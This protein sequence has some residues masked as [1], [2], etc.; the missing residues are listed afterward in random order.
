[1]GK[2]RGWWFAWTPLRD[3]YLPLADAAVGSSHEQ[4]LESDRVGSRRTRR[5]ARAHGRGVR[6]R[7]SADR[8]ASR[9]TDL[10][11]DDTVLQPQPHREPLSE[12]RPHREPLVVGRRSRR[13]LG[14]VDLGRLE[15]FGRR[16]GL[17]GS[18][19]TGVGQLGERFGR[20]GWFEF[21]FGHFRE[22]FGRL[23]RFGIGLGRAR[24]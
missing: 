13:W 8:A 5:G 10:H 16:R 23:G 4:D 17:Q 24:R 1:M 9:R 20:V 18:R 11:D 19:G 12:T 21:G 14:R 3:L 6:D 7:R 22:R 2:G 15:R